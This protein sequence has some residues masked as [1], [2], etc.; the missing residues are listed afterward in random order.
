LGNFVKGILVKGRLFAHRELAKQ[1]VKAIE[2]LQKSNTKRKM[3]WSIEGGV[4]ERD[5]KTQKITKSIIRNVVLTMNPV[6]TMTWAELAKSFDKHNEVTV[7]LEVPEIPEAPEHTEVQKALNVA[8]VEPINR[9]SIEGFDP[10][11]DVQSR[12]IKLF[13]KFVKRNILDK[14]LRNQ[15]VAST[16][17]AAGMK[18]YI[19]ALG[20]GLDNEEAFEFASYISDK[21]EI[22][23]SIMSNFGGE[24][25]AKSALASLLDTDLE[26]LEKSLNEDKGDEDDNSEGGEE[27]GKGN[28]DEDG[29]EGGDNDDDDD[30]KDGEGTE[31]DDDT[32]KS[33]KTDFAKSLA[34]NEEN[35][36]AL[37]VSEFLSNLADEIGYSIETL[38]KSLTGVA[39]QQTAVVKALASVGQLIKGLTE[40]VEGMEAENTELK[41][42]LDELAQKPVGRKSVVSTKEIQTITKSMGQENNKGQLTKAQAMD[43][44]MKSFD[45]GEIPGMTVSRYEAG[46]PLTSLG[47]PD[48]V[49]TKLGM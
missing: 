16:A 4:R 19:Y 23:K 44:L 20:E 42:S 15:F 47:L 22:L 10:E 3:G 49:K 40:K 38:T 43:I 46:V 21:H 45:A 33:L 24:K 29:G 32:E 18:S 35:R 39:N 37:E 8:A 41:K 1:A 36:E 26:E 27:E 6:N 5:R 13:R 9:Q 7:S 14:S 28:E 25:M 31:D 2:D 17:G 30:D 11:K 48:G 34:A 12:W